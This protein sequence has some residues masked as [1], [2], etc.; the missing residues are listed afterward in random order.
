MTNRRNP[1]SS[2]DRERLTAGQCDELVEALLHDVAALADGRE[3]KNL[4]K[5]AEGYREL[6]NLKRTVLRKVN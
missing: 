2:S 4:L 6:A 3:R 1:T 5:L